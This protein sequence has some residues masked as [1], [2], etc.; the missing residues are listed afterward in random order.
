M[1]LCVQAGKGDVKLPAR[2]AEVRP[3]MDEQ[4]ALTTS[5]MA[6]VPQRW[7]RGTVAPDGRTGPW[8]LAAGYTHL[9]VYT[10]MKRGGLLR[11]CASGTWFRTG[12][13]CRCGTGRLATRKQASPPHRA[14]SCCR[15]AQQRCSKG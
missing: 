12:Q 1:T 11:A 6:R 7:V 5:V 8:R 4:M 14:C 2:M 15:A 13:A 10:H 3:S 9:C